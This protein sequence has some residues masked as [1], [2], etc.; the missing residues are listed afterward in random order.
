MPYIQ[1]TLAFAIDTV[2]GLYLIVVLLRFVFQQCR[3]DHRNPLSVA[4]IRL[5]DTPLRAFRRMVPGL[6]GIDMACLVLALAISMIQIAL[7]MGV[8]GYS[9]DIPAI[10]VLALND[11]L[12]TMIWILIIAILAAAIMSWF[13]RSYHP[14]LYLAVQISEPVLR[15]FRSLL[16]AVGG[17]D[18]S[19]LLA[20]F[21]LN[22]LLRL[23]VA[24]I[25]DFGRYLI[26]G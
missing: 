22:L 23:V 2:L 20:L 1:N 24:P 17:L 13:M 21:V 16:P 25:G 7:I 12:K 9:L 18:L 19:P 4:I 11:V 3:A 8:S 6:F 26:Y 14:V 5:T 10:A 15:P